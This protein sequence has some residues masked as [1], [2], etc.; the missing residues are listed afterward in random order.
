MHVGNTMLAIKRSAGVA[1][2]VNLRNPL[3]T[4]QTAHKQGIHSGFETQGKCHQKSLTGVSVALEKRTCFLQNFF[5]KS[6]KR[7][8]EHKK[9]YLTL[10]LPTITIVLFANFPIFAH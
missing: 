7:E 4:G 6:P 3:C 8:V 10:M 1:P 2:E 5:L 9:F